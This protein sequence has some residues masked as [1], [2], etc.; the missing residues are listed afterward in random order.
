M[1]ILEKLDAEGVKLEKSQ[2]LK[3]AYIVFGAKQPLISTE[4]FREGLFY[5]QDKASC[6]AAEAADPKPKMTVL[7]VCAAPGAKTTYIAQ[8]MQN[9]G[10]ICSVDYSIRRMQA[11]KREVGADGREN[12]VSRHRRRLRSYAICAGSRCRSFGPS[13]HEHWRFCQAAFSQVA[14]HS[15]VY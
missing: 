14:A 10:N 3:H 8:L 15:R 5:I 1:R 7:D 4:S 13:V 6:F 11:W 2:P 12:S 9:Q